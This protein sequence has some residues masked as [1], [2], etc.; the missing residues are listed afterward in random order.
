MDV[1]YIKR[2]VCIGLGF[3]TLS[4]YF[5]RAILLCGDRFFTVKQA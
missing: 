4:S 3:A 1:E 2:G 5:T